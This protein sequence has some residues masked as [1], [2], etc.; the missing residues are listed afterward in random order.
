VFRCPNI[1]TKLEKKAAFFHGPE[2]TETPSP[3]QNGSDLSAALREGRNTFVADSM[4]VM[5]GRML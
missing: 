3:K 4:H 2:K 5:N 1:Q